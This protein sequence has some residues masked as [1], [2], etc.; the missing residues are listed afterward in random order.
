[1]RSPGL[2]LEAFQGLFNGSFWWLDL[3]VTHRTSFSLCQS[4][5]LILYSLHV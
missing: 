3:L 4:L 1:M 2:S 5:G